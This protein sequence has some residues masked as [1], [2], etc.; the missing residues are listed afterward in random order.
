MQVDILNGAATI[1]VGNPNRVLSQIVQS[2]VTAG[3]DDPTN[4]EVL[5]SYW[6]AQ[7]VAGVDGVA[8]NDADNEEAALVW[9]LHDE[10]EVTTNYAKLYQ[11]FMQLDTNTVYELSDV[12]KQAI[13]A[14]LA[15]PPE[16]QVE[17]ANALDPE[18]VSAET[19]S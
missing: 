5:Y 10:C 16:L 19:D 7:F 15:A 9:Q 11:L 8:V 3:Q 17:D 12:F 1:E 4:A 18:A 6:F 13:D 2:R 14:R